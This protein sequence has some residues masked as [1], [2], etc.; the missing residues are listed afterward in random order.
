VGLFLLRRNIESARKR[1]ASWLITMFFGSF[2]K[3]E[4][5]DGFHPGGIQPCRFI[6]IV[7]PNVVTSL[8]RFK[9]SAPSRCM[10]VQNA[11]ARFRA[12]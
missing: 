11:T 6:H 12:N 4:T 8:K 7:V 10:N 9:T 1:K 5:G 2:V 3:I